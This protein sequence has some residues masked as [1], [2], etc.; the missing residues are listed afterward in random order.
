MALNKQACSADFDLSQWTDWS[1]GRP[2]FK[3]VPE[4]AS[5]HHRQITHRQ[6]SGRD[7]GILEV[8]QAN[9]IRK[10]Q[11]RRRS[12]RPTPRRQPGRIPPPPRFT[13]QQEANALQTQSS[14]E[15]FSLPHPKC[16]TQDQFGTDASSQINPAAPHRRRAS[17]PPRPIANQP[18]PAFLAQVHPTARSERS[19]DSI[20]KGILLP[21]LTR[22][23]ARKTNLELTPHRKLTLPRRPRGQVHPTAKANSNPRSTASPP[24]RLNRLIAAQISQ[25]P[26]LPRPGSPHSKKQTPSAPNDPE[27]FAL[28]TTFSTQLRPHLNPRP[29][30]PPLP[31]PGSPHSK[32]RTPFQTQGQSISTR[33]ALRST[34]HRPHLKRR[35]S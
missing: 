5:E 10:H 21:F 23:A 6:R 33:P 1:C 31:R 24:T 2:R 17:P 34:A 28:F 30:L 14:K 22:S 13:P 27:I 29:P 18:G 19:S 9:S 25:A 8:L 32:K 35:P 20:V 12:R 15:S 3:A 7:T 16:S 26:L 4:L 11:K